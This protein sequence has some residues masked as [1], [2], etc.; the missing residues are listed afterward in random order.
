MKKYKN[1]RGIKKYKKG[2]V[3]WWITWKRNCSL[4]IIK[5]SF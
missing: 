1:L 2:R 5:G 4:I 3:I